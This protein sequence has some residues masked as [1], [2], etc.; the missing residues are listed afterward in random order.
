MCSS[1][2]ERR[3]TSPS[4]PQQHPEEQ[5]VAPVDLARLEG[6]IHRSKVK[7]RGRSS[8]GE[9][10]EEERKEIRERKEQGQ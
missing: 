2:R 3:V 8:K 9:I 1:V 6:R 5:S 4:L 10:K 7:M